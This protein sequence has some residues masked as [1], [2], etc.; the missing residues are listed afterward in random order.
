MFGERQA[1]VASI[2]GASGSGTDS[3]EFLPPIVSN[4]YRCPTA[5]TLVSVL[6]RALADEPKVSVCIIYFNPPTAR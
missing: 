1:L 6:E 3:F 5:K 2:S 4:P